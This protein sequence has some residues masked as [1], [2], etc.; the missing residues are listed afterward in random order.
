MYLATLGSS[1]VDLVDAFGSIW[2]PD[3]DGGSVVR[4]NPVTLKIMATINVGGRPLAITS[5]GGAVWVACVRSNRLIRIDPGATKVSGSV[6]IRDLPTG[7]TFED[8][9]V[10]VSGT[11]DN[12][13]Q[14]IDDANMKVTDVIPVGSYSACVAGRVGAGGLCSSCCTA[15][16]LDLHGRSLI[17]V[18]CDRSAAAGSLAGGVAR[19]GGSVVRGRRGQGRA[20]GGGGGADR[21]A[22]GAGRGAGASPG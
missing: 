14:R 21:R 1:P 2:V 4:L 6:A 20:A 11:T 19:V 17:M 8:N 15:C 5:G 10:W 7:I 22:D 13:V 9:A 16:R 18:S 12:V 3:G